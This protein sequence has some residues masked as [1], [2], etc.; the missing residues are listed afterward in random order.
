MTMETIKPFKAKQHNPKPQEPKRA[1]LRNCTTT[2]GPHFQRFNSPRPRISRLGDQKSQL[3]QVTLTAFCPPP[4]QILLLRTGRSAPVS[5]QKSLSWNRLLTSPCTHTSGQAASHSKAP[6]AL[7]GFKKTVNFCW[8]QKAK[9]KAEVTCVRTLV[10]RAA[11]QP[12][13]PEPAAG[14]QAWWIS[15]PCFSPRQRS[16][17]LSPPMPPALAQTTRQRLAL[18][19]RGSSAPP[20]HPRLTAAQLHRAPGSGPKQPRLFPP[21]RRSLPPAQPQLLREQPLCSAPTQCPA[22][23]TPPL[24]APETPYQ[25]PSYP[26]LLPHPPPGD[27]RLPSQHP[28]AEPPSHPRAPCPSPP[29]HGAARPL[30]ARRAQRPRPVPRGAQL[31][32]RGGPAA[33]TRAPSPPPP[34]PAPPAPTALPPMI[35]SCFFRRDLRLFMARP[36][37]GGSGT[38][39]ATR[40]PRRR[41]RRHGRDEPAPARRGTLNPLPRPPRGAQPIIARPRGRHGQSSSG[42]WGGT[43]SFETPPEVGRWERSGRA[44][45]RSHRAGGSHRA[46]A[47]RPRQRHDTARAGRCAAPRWRRGGP[48]GAPRGGRPGR[49]RPGRGR[50]AALRAAVQRGRNCQ[51]WWRQERRTQPGRCACKPLPCSRGAIYPSRS[52]R[53][54]GSS[55]E[56]GAGDSPLLLGGCRVWV[57]AL[58]SPSR[59]STRSPVTGGGTAPGRV[60]S[61]Q[62]SGCLMPA[63]GLCENLARCSRTGVAQSPGGV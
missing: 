16:G 36:G 29:P 1:R 41:H 53:P 12:G 42:S 22:A 38:G 5:P 24:P 6:Q 46:G 17:I 32:K 11:G 28:S 40:R 20:A 2:R 35:A 8:S 26:A 61:A 3:H 21:S 56:N 50:P 54:G 30:P 33:L 13:Q 37:A 19:P 25:L 7:T 43:S 59:P 47:D 51:A 18:R 60:R 34:G 39:P 44:G 27:P 52:D 15:S 48:A 10:F 4:T 9:P 62:S 57:T 63:R 55:V 31:P 49:A 14:C 58:N 23:C 45:S